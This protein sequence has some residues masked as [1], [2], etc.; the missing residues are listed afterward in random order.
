VVLSVEVSVVVV[1]IWAGSEAEAEA[2]ASRYSFTTVD[3]K[4]VFPRGRARM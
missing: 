4:V 1:A 3:R 2:R